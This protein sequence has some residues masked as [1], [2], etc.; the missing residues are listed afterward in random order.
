M[1]SIIAFCALIFTT[2]GIKLTEGEELE[3]LSDVKINS[4]AGSFD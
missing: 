4:L 1:K 3:K 2:E